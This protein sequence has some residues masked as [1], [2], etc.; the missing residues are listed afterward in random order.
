MWDWERGFPFGVK[1]SYCLE[2]EEING[3]EPDGFCFYRASDTIR[4]EA[5]DD[6]LSCADDQLAT[7]CSFRYVEAIGTPD[8]MTANPEL[9]AMSPIMNYI[10]GFITFEDMMAL[11]SRYR[12]FYCMGSDT[13]AGCGFNAEDPDPE[14]PPCAVT[15]D[16]TDRNAIRTSQVERYTFDDLVSANGGRRDPP[17]RAEKDLRHGFILLSQRQASEAEMTL[18]T[19]LMRHHEVENVPHARLPTANGDRQNPLVTWLYTTQGKSTLHSKLHGISCGG[20]LQ[21]P[22]CSNGANPCRRVS[23]GENAGCFNLDGRAFCQCLF[24][25]VGD[26]ALCV[27][28]NETV[29]YPLASAYELLADGRSD[30]FGNDWPA[31]IAANMIPQYPGGIAPFAAE[32]GAQSPSPSGCAANDVIC[33]V[34]QFIITLVSSFLSSI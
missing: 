27:L 26:G 2:D 8:A 24:G 32:Q 12:T 10:A 31:R 34:V 19:M 16:D 30:C 14:Q 9:F 21:V 17:L 25:F 22:S 3:P 1:T 11:P 29:Q 28:P 5:N 33:S 7:C 20:G 13:D 18:Y 4:L 23:C 6:C 15:V